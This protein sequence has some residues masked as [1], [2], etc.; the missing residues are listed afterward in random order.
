MNTDPLTRD[1]MERITEIMNGR[2]FV[3]MHWREN[4]RAY[5]NSPLGDKMKPLVIRAAQYLTEGHEVDS[6]GYEEDDDWRS[7]I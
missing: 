2:A 6:V 3:T 5:S 4:D 7:L 1:D